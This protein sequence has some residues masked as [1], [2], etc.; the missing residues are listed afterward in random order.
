MKQE[1]DDIQQT[2]GVGPGPDAADVVGSKPDVVS[3]VDV[4]GSK[5]AA[6]IPAAVREARTPRWYVLK[7]TYGREQKANDYLVEHGIRTF[8]PTLRVKKKVDGKRVSLE[9]SRLPNLFFAYGTEKGLTPLVQQNPEMPCLRFY[10]RYSKR[11]DRPRRELIT[12]PQYQMDALMRICAAD[13]MDTRIY[14]EIIRKFHTGALVR[15]TQGPFAGVVGRVARFDGQQRVAIDIG[16][17]FT[18]TTSYIPTSCL[19]RIEE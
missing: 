13:K 7:T 3:A 11:P 6:D 8:Y 17:L 9:E 14:P 16:E 15:V 12:V 5:P 2:T 10:C 18:A 4:I 19:E 1:N